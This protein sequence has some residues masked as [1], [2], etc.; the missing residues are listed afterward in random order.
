M[1][2][3][4]VSPTQ[5]PEPRGIFAEKEKKYSSEPKIFKHQSP[6]IRFALEIFFFI[7]DECGVFFF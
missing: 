4:A 6:L 1:Y 3:S 5:F 2:S 7:W